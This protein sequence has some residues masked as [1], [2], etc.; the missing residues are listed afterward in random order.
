MHGGL[1]RG[2]GLVRWDLVVVDSMHEQ[3]SEPGLV[4]KE[5]ISG[6]KTY[7]YTPKIQAQNSVPQQPIVF[8]ALLLNTDHK[9][10]SH[11]SR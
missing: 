3:A 10:R 4:E 7:T 6:H 2:L 8:W 5:R 9:K 11:S 1:S